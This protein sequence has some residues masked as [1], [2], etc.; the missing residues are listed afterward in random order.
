MDDEAEKIGGALHSH[1]SKDL[2]DAIEAGDYPS[3]TLKVQ[4]MDPATEN[5]YDF[6]PLDA[7]K[8]WPEDQFPLREVRV[9]GEG[10]GEGGR[11][12]V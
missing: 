10:R 9:G 11:C 6:D 7:T 8:T 2:Y 1:A 5:D 12:E 3:W 4:T